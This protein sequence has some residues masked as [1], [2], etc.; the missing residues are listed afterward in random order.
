M[1]LKFRTGCLLDLLYAGDLVIMYKSLDELLDKMKVWKQQLET[2][3]VRVNIDT[4]N[5]ADVFWTKSQ[6]PD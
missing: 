5:L 1:S 3:G 2:K 4:T 6:F